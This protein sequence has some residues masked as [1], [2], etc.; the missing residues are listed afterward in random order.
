MAPSDSTVSSVVASTISASVDPFL[1][2]L[3]G[4]SDGK[5][6]LLWAHSFERFLVAHRKTSHLTDP[7]P[8]RTSPE[9]ADWYV[10]DAAVSNWILNSIEPRIAHPYMLLHPA[11]LG[12]PSHCLW[13]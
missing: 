6:Y 3:S 12:C 11:D 2:N 4:T 1:R 13:S 10:M 5:N 9:F 8:A 7:P